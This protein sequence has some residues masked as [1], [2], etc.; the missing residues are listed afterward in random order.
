MMSCVDFGIRNALYI[1]S[2]EMDYQ[3]CSWAVKASGGVALQFPRGDCL[4]SQTI[5]IKLDE[6][7]RI[8]DALC[9]WIYFGHRERQWQRLALIFFASNRS[10][11]PKGSFLVEGTHWRRA[12]R[13]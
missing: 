7:G 2:P 13:R 12:A 3:S 6:V 8:G 1:D 11:D 10:N 4:I 9:P 5:K